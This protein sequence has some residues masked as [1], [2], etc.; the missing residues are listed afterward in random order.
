MNFGKSVLM[1]V[2]GVSLAIA[3]VTAAK[4]A[5]IDVP[6]L[7]GVAVP[8]GF[9]AIGVAFLCTDLLGELY[10]REAARHAV[11]ATIIALAVGWT[12]VYAAI[13]LPAAP[14]YEG[15]A[16]FTS[17]LGASTSI[18]AASILTMLVSQNIDVSVFH[19]LRE[20]T[21][22][23]HKWLRNVGSTATS[24]LVDTALFIG[25]GFVVFPPVFGGTAVP[26]AVIPTMIVGQYVVK[27]GVAMADTPLFY[28]LSGVSERLS[29]VEHV[30]A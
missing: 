2:F 30:V 19:Y 24:Q 18:V 23:R 26:L 21:S 15:S 7:G 11:N 27:V 17:V 6:L 5:F 28:V 9:I 16:A 4:I 20:H 3:N 25:L 1:T 8:A 29:V 13:W 10:G 22:G 14:F 12:L